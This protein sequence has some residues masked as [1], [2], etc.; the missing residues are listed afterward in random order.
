AKSELLYMDGQIYMGSNRGYY[1]CLN[2]NSGEKVWIS[3]YTD[4]FATSP[5]GIDKN[6]KTVHTMESGM[7]EQQ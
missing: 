5:I 1:Y 6:G 2:A 3:E 4:F 7:Y